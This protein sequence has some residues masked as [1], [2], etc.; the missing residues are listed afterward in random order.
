MVETSQKT[1]P[2]IALLLPIAIAIVLAALGLFVSEDRKIQLVA[3]LVGILTGIGVR[4]VLTY[5]DLNSQYAQIGQTVN[6]LSNELN[7]YSLVNQRAASVADVLSDDEGYQSLIEFND[8]YNRLADVEKKFPYIKEMVDWKK[9]RVRESIRATL[10]E[11][12]ETSIVIDDPV[13]ELTSNADL[14]LAVPE[15]R[16]F[17]VSYEDVE[18]WL[19]DEG[20]EFL[21]VNRQVIQR[22]IE[23]IRVFVGREEVL[24]ELGSIMARNVE[25]GASVFALDIKNAS[26]L[27]PQDF[28]IYDSKLVRYGYNP[29]NTLESK[30]KH[31][32][33]IIDPGKVK[34][35]LGKAEALRR[36]ARQV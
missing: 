28:V 22:G 14:L 1:H 21:E 6:E 10:N 9:G 25:I 19:S 30:F 27:S 2:Y 32:S 24:F 13:R 8:I 36:R 34:D 33:I 20:E 31:A 18:F 12:R 29:N 15:E 7:A 35:A 26:G 17:A 5:N 16:V 23:I 3:S 4:L 11:L